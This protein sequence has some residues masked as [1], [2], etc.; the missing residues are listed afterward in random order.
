MKAEATN[1]GGFLVTAETDEETL[2]LER[3]YR[4]FCATPPGHRNWHMT[5][6]QQP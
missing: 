4:L 6:R 1:D 3:A 2:I 5:M